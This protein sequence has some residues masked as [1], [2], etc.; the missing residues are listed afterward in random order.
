MYLESRRLDTAEIHYISDVSMRQH[1]TTFWIT[2][3][4]SGFQTYD[5]WT[6]E[7]R[8]KDYVL[9]VPNIIT[10]KAHLVQLL[11]MFHMHSAARG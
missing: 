9:G 2:T 11:G 1:H 4:G 5:L 7:F 8:V 6:G 3:I 10:T